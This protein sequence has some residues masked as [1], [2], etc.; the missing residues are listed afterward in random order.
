MKHPLTYLENIFIEQ[1]LFDPTFF[2]NKQFFWLKLFLTIFLTKQFSD[3]HF[4]QTVFWPNYRL[5]KKKVPNRIWYQ[6]WYFSA[7]NASA[8]V[9][10]FIFFNGPVFVDCQAALDY[11]PMGFFTESWSK[12][13]RRFQNSKFESKTTFPGLLYKWINIKLTITNPPTYLFNFTL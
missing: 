8:I 4:D 11:I 10:L 13:H 6:E 2:F 12:Y 9:S 7:S 5:S 1:N 3:I